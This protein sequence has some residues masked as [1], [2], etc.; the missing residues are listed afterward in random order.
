MNGNALLLT[1]SWSCPGIVARFNA[2]SLACAY[3]NHCPHCNTQKR[4]QACVRG[5]SHAIRAFTSGHWR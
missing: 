2:I 3:D 5:T 1:E 4:L